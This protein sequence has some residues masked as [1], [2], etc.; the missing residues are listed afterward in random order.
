MFK[1]VRKTCLMFKNSHHH[2]NPNTKIDLVNRGLSPFI[3]LSKILRKLLS[4]TVNN[5]EKL[6]ATFLCVCTAGSNPAASAGSPKTRSRFG[7]CGDVK[8]KP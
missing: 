6:Q 3:A 2:P 7:F 1:T 4:K 5:H 8:G